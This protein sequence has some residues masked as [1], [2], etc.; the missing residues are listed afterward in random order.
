MGMA[1]SNLPTAGVLARVSAVAQEDEGTSLDSQVEA[2]VAQALA[3]GYSV[4]EHH[5]WRDADVDGSTEKQSG[6]LRGVSFSRAD[7]ASGVMGHLL[8][9]EKSNIRLAESK[10]YLVDE[11]RKLREV[12]LAGNDERL[13]LNRLWS[14]VASGEVDGVFIVGLNRL[15]SDPWEMVWFSRHCAVHGV[16]LWVSGGRNGYR[17]VGPGERVIGSGRSEDGKRPFVRLVKGKREVL[18]VFRLVS[19]GFSAGDIARRMNRL[20]S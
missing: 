13:V 8:R 3:D 7:G 11:E 12:G 9:Q 19:A 1:K 5:I 15:Y 17:V 20:D 10:G 14:M 4:A 16:E 2:C 18:M 6:P